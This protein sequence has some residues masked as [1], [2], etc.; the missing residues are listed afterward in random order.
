M[1]TTNKNISKNFNKF[2]KPITKEELIQRAV[3]SEEDIK[4]GNIISLEEIK[5]Q[6]ETWKKNNFDSKKYPSKINP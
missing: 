6:I 2:F 4:N 1:D 5:K 3:E